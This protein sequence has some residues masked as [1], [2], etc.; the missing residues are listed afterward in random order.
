M[1][2]R[3]LLRDVYISIESLRKSFD[4]L[5]N[6]MPLWIEAKITFRPPMGDAWVEEQCMLWDTLGLDPETS[7]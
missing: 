7:T 1:K 4:L 6:Y 2:D 5:K 3:A